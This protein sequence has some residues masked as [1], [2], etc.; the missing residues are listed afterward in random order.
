MFIYLLSER[1]REHKQGGGQRE[2][3]RESQAG[4]APSVHGSVIPTV[5]SRLEPKSRVDR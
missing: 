3:E 4:S 5:S 1:D 2:K